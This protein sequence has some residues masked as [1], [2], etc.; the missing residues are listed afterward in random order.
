[1]AVVVTAWLI[2]ESTSF[3]FALVCTSIVACRASP[4]EPAE[5]VAAFE[6]PFGMVTTVT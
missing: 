3:D 2:A 6:K 5:E 1:M 4:A